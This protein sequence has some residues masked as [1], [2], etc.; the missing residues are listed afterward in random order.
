LRQLLGIGDGGFEV[1]V[2]VGHGVS[3]G[4]LG[5]AILNSRRPAE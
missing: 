2:E 1:G 3:C 5:S 4:S